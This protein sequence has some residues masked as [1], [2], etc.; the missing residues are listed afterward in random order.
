M[1]QAFKRWPVMTAGRYGDARIRRKI[2]GASFFR[3][4]PG[5]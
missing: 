3:L 4:A 1:Y 5:Q 2:N